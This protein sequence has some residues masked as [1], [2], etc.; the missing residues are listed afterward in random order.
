MNFL[1]YLAEALFIAYLMKIASYR[2][3]IPSVSG[4]VIGGVLLGG[5]LFYWIPGGREFSERWLFESTVREQFTIVTQIA[6]C[7][8][9]LSIGVE[10]EWRRIRKLGRSILFITFF[11]ATAAFLVV[12][13]VTYLIWQDFS[14]SLILG[15]VS[16]ATAPAA[17]VAVIQQF[18]AK[19]PLTTTILTVVGIDDAMSLVIFAF[20]LTVTKGFLQGEH[21]SIAL[22]IF[23]PFLEI[24][25]SIVIGGGLGLISAGLIAKTTDSESI[26]FIIGAMILFISGISTDL[27][28]SPL[29]ANMTFGSVLVNIHSYVKNRIRSSFSSFMP[30]FYALFFLVGGAYLD[31]T[32]FPTIWLM[33]VVYFGCR[34]TGKVAGA[35]FGAVLGRSLPQ[36]RRYI[37]LSLLPQVGVAIALALV[38]YKEFGSGQYGAEGIRLAR[39][40]MN[41]LLITTLLTEFVGPYLTKM[42][43]KK[44]GEINA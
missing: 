24:V 21:I 30:V 38:I 12:A 16:S 36:V 43:L 19:G 20:A 40:T 29:L 27:D 9:A 28:L 10:L 7:I 17:T 5:S 31:V 34:F 25:L 39:D 42:S 15:A 13:V 33:A 3:G 4:Y 32:V 26:I 2:I 44:T 41:I 14:L 18:K 6:L 23:K 35:S 1:L 8:I 22:G 11:E 37:G